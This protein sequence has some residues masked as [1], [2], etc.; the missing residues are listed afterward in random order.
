MRAILRSWFLA[1]A[2]MALTVP[3]NAGPFE[4]GF[5][6]FTRADTLRLAAVMLVTETKQNQ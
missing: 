5:A 2:I 6:A 3:A 4:D 1:L